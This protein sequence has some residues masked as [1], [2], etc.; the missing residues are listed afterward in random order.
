MSG[1]EEVLSAKTSQE[2]TNTLWRK[3]RTQKKKSLQFKPTK[4]TNQGAIHPT[5]GMY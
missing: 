5:K 1:L 2:Y 3:R 4:K